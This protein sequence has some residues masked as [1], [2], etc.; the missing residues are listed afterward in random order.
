MNHGVSGYACTGIPGD[1]QE[2]RIGTPWEAS[3]N[4]PAA[5]YSNA[6][7]HLGLFMSGFNESWQSGALDDPNMSAQPYR[8][9]IVGSFEAPA[10]PKIADIE[11]CPIDYPEHLGE[12]YPQQLPSSRIHVDPTVQAVDR[13]NLGFEAGTVAGTHSAMMPHGNVNTQPNSQFFQG[14]TTVAGVHPNN[15]IAGQQTT[16]NT[17]KQ[18]FVQGQAPYQKLPNGITINMLQPQEPPALFQLAPPPDPP[19]PVGGTAPLRPTNPAR[20]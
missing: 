12:T 8:T 18:E 4:D 20:W 10:P 6:Q 16:A 19:V 15:D 13:Q 7:N 9:P 17:G 11:I 1:F 3:P 2:E 14:S 5:S